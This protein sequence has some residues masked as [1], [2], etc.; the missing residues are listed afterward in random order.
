MK[1]RKR[2]AAALCVGAAAAGGVLAAAG[3]AS[4]ESIAFPQ[5][6][7]KWTLYSTVDRY[8]SKQYRELYTSAE[9]VKAVREGRPIPDGTV[10]VMAIHSA[11]VDDKSTPVKDAKGRFVKDKLGGVT[12]MEKRKGSGVSIPDDWR[13][14]DWQYASFTHD[15]K[16]NEKANA[17]IKNCFVCHKPHEKQDFVI[18]LAQLAGKFPSGPVAMKSGMHD[19]NITGFS[20]GPT[21]LKVTAGQPVTWTNGDDSP[22]QV[23]L[24]G[25]KPQRTAVL[26]KGQS[27]T[28]KFDEAGTFGYICGLHPSMKGSV[29]VTR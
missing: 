21:A 29:E 18:S 1:P 15:G 5:D 8:D 25:D 26:L 9:A 10:I 11:K 7:Q 3:S 17:G 23:T 2:I 4:P 19:V 13:N 27:A 20:F 14:G 28:L 6:Y 24:T 22:H 16:P 12:V